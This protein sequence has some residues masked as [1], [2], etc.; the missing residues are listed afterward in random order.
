MVIY[1]AKHDHGKL[2]K[3]DKI[4]EF[5]GIEKLDNAEILIDAYNKLHIGVIWVNVASSIKS[6]GIETFLTFIFV[7]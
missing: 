5:I 6:E 7:P 1:F 2:I 3:S 4:K